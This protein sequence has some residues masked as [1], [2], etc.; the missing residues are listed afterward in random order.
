MS[1]YDD[2]ILVGHSLSTQLED[3][4][5][6]IISWD[7]KILAKFAPRNF[8][9]IV[10]ASWISQ[11]EILYILHLS[12]N[13]QTIMVT[14]SVLD[15]RIVGASSCSNVSS[16]CKFF[17]SNDG[18]IYF[19][20]DDKR[21]VYQSMDGG[22]SWSLVFNSTEG[23]HCF[24]VIVHHKYYF[25]TLERS[26]NYSY[27]LFRYNTAENVPKGNVKVTSVNIT[28][29]GGSAIQLS[30]FTSM[31]YDN[32]NHIFLSDYDN[33]AVHVFLVSG[34]YHCRLLSLKQ[35]DSNPYKLTLDVVRR[36][37][38]VGYVGSKVSVFE[39]T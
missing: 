37:L 35:L 1:V 3:T 27:R 13:G 14:M 8:G 12:D 33:V 25:W 10:D 28:T 39:L 21:G 38:Y 32:Y 34:E 20:D 36:H 26:S 22:K 16:F 17:V 7:G 6:T 23:W 11:N 31:A 5:F 24:Q 30:Q 4:L 9:T 18:I 29:P 15:G 19:A 2:A